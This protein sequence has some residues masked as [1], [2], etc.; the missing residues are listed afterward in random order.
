MTLAEDLNLI[1][2]PTPLSLPRIEISQF[3]HER[4][5]QDSGHRWFRSTIH[6]LFAA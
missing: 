4:M 6:S 5:H 1:T 3:W 2:F